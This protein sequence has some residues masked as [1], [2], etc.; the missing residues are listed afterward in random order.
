VKSTDTFLVPNGQR[1]PHERRPRKERLNLRPRRRL[2][3]IQMIAG[4]VA[5]VAVVEEA[6]AEADEEAPVGEG[7]AA[8]EGA[9]AGRSCNN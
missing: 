4:L 5:V 2:P 9:E 7:V 3:K 8:A 1:I 6:E